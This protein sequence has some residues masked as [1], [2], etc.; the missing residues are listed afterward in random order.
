LKKMSDEKTPAVA[1][2]VTAP[3]DNNVATTTPPPIPS[4]VSNNNETTTAADTS[5]TDDST[6]GWSSTM[7]RQ[8]NNTN[9]FVRGKWSDIATLT[10]NAVSQWPVKSFE[11]DPFAPLLLIALMTFLG[12]G[13]LIVSHATPWWTCD[14]WSGEHFGLWN[15]CF[16]SDGLSHVLPPVTG[17]D[18]N[19][20]I[21]KKNVHKHVLPDLHNE[22]TLWSWN[23][24]PNATTITTTV[25]SPVISM[26][27]C[28]QQTLGHVTTVPADK[29]RADHVT[30]AQGLMISGNILYFLSWLA[31]LWAWSWQRSGHHTMPP[32]GTSAEWLNHVRNFLTFCVVAQV[33]AFLLELVGLFLYIWTGRY[34]TSVVLLFFYFGLAIIST[35]ITNFITIEY[36]VFK[37]RHLTA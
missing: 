6:A 21:V 20:I 3:T 32:V 11:R 13:S 12:V 29:L 34:S 17:V 14:T 16:Q 23:S 2:I 1:P 4:N 9:K 25:E 19:T 8:L 33:F 10:H 28:A 36:K 5:T 7:R 22:T 18:G 27:K 35:N 30:Y 15:T 24:P 26:W 37:Q 31:L